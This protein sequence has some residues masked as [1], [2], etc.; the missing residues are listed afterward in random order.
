MADWRRYGDTPEQACAD[1]IERYQDRIRQVDALYAAKCELGA[2]LLE[3]VGHKDGDHNP[4]WDWRKRSAAALATWD[5]QHADEALKRIAK[6]AA[7]E[8]VEPS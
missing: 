5:I 7:L 4:G 3:A 8:E 6:L 1:L 2:L